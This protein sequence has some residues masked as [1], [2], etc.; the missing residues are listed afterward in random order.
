MSREALLQS[1]S[2][3]SWAQ[4]TT[5]LE[6]GDGKDGSGSGRGER[7]KDGYQKSRGKK[8]AK[9]MVSCLKPGCKGECYLSV[10]EKGLK[11]GG[12]PATCRICT[13]KYKLPPGTTPTEDGQNKISKKMADLEAKLAKSQEEI[14]T[15]KAKVIGT[16]TML[17][18]P[19]GT[20][21][22]S[23]QRTA[24]WN[25]A[26]IVGRLVPRIGPQLGVLP[27]ANRDIDLTDL[28]PLVGD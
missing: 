13:R 20:V 6:M 5:G 26:P 22:S 10:V 18:E 23:F 7:S 11:P 8:A 9:R 12:N 4:D 14:Q 15:L 27:D 1:P 3:F 19:K 28:R 25:A 16:N 24:A 17:D 2:P 21:A